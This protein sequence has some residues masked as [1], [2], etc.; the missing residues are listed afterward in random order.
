MRKYL[1]IMA[2]EGH[3]WGGS[4][5]L[6]SEAAEKL[7]RQGNEVRVSAKDWGERVPQIERLRI[8]GCQIFYRK[9]PLPRFLTRQVR[10]IFPK[11]EYRVG[12]VRSVGNG[13]DL[14]VISQGANWDGLEWIEAARAAGRRYAIISQGAGDLWW[15]DDDTA[16]RVAAC[17]EDASA[18][19]FVSQANVELSRRQ[20]GSPLGNAKVVRNPFN[21]SYDARPAWPDGLPS[22]LSL[23][24]VARLDVAQKG[25]D[26]LLQV[27]S[28]PRWRERKVHVSIVGKGPNGRLLHRAAEELQ[29]TNV[30]FTGHVEDVEQVWSKHHAF[31]LASRYEGMP[32][33]LIEAMLCGRPG[34]VTDVAGHREL[35]RDGVNGFLA[36]APTVELLDEAMN[37]AWECRGRLKA[38]G[39]TAAADV[40]AWVSPDPAEDFARE[41]M[42]LVDGTKRT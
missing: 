26:L 24:C 16:D 28:L 29:L 4:E 17:Y 20:F 27:L 23:A 31:V 30:E 10:K 39:E 8:A 40:R 3:Q 34:I 38:M 36:K 22:G 19:Y 42:S 7:A 35:I 2:N 33:A 6:W 37:R 11:P 32:L 14:I 1:F 9:N 13:T 15:P 25:Q 41:L 18:A 5:P 21:V 12:H